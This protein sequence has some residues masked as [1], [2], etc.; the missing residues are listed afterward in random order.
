VPAKAK[1]APRPPSKVAGVADALELLESRR[2]R[3]S[4]PKAKP[5]GRRGDL[6]LDGIR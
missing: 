2:R 1:P 5:A 6:D 4:A 3:A